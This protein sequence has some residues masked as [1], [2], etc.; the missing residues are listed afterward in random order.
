MLPEGN[1]QVICAVVL[2]K[3]E[4]RGMLSTFASCALPIGSVRIKTKRRG[5]GVVVIS[6]RA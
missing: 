2:R 3:K 4:V 5:D 1:Y 6:L